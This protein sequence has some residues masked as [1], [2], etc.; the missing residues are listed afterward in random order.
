MTDSELKRFN[1]NAVATLRHVHV[2]RIVE[3]TRNTLH[4]SSLQVNRELAPKRA[5]AKRFAKTK[6]SGV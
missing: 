5:A 2:V 6:P 1:A 3:Q 4:E